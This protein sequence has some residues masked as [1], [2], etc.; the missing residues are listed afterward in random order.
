MTYY[1]PDIFGHTDAAGAYGVPTDYS[2]Q[3]DPLSFLEGYLQKGLRGPS[4]LESPRE[5]EFFEQWVEE[6]R[7]EGGVRVDPNKLDLR[8]FRDPTA[9]VRPGEFLERDRF[10]LGPRSPLAQITPGMVRNVYTGYQGDPYII[11]P[12]DKLNMMMDYRDVL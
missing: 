1:T 6:D 7:P 2:G 8:E 10:L 3:V 11:T 4:R 9:P 12:E 5:Q